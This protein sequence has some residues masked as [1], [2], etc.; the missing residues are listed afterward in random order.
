MPDMT[1]ASHDPPLCTHK[2]RCGTT[3]HAAF[4]KERDLCDTRGRNSRRKDGGGR[5]GATFVQEEPG[6]R[7]T[8]ERA[9]VDVLRSNHARAQPEGTTP[10][11]RVDQTDFFRSRRQLSCLPLVS[12]QVLGRPRTRRHGCP[13][14]EPCQD[15]GTWLI[16]RAFFPVVVS[17]ASSN[18]LHLLGVF[19]R[20]GH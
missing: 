10:R 19:A 14:I 4:S 6:P 15:T 17:L 20:A 1:D 9:N 8:L 18:I 12:A 11:S 3:L 16:L 2:R 13:P 5:G 7:S